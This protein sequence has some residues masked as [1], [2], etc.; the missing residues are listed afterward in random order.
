MSEPI[1]NR[2]V[3]RAGMGISRRASAPISKAIL[4]ATGKRNLPLWRM[5]TM[6]YD[7][8][9]ST[10]RGL[11]HDALIVRDPED[12]ELKVGDALMSDGCVLTPLDSWE[13]GCRDDGDRVCV[14]VPKGWTEIS[15]IAASDYWDLHVKGRK[16]DKVAIARLLAKSVCGDWLSGKV[17]L[18]SHFYCTEGVQASFER[19][20]LYPYY[21]NK[22]ATPGTTYRRLMD[23][24]LEPV[25]GALTEYGRKFAVDLT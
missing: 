23:K 8:Y 16:Y 25:P 18:L 10:I 1:F 2:D 9:V 20:G 6:G 3:L 21:P 19:A 22:N 13:R 11:T 14:W 17:G 15:G 7:G 4:L 12:G 24:R 5:A